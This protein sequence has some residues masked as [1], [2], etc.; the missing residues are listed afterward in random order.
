[1]TTVLIAD[2]AMRIRTR[3]PGASAMPEPEEPRSNS[4]RMLFNL[5]FLASGYTILTY[6]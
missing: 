4:T 1:M 6:A 5:T 2:V 3:S